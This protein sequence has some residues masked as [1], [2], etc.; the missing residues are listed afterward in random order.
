ML[1]RKLFKSI[2]KVTVVIASL[3]VITEKVLKIID[4]IIENNKTSVDTYENMCP[5]F[6][7]KEE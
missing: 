2:I 5:Y 3:I 6:V 7:E 1:I 4:F